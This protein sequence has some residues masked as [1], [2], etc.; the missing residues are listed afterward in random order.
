M[1][2][3]T[4]DEEL[5]SKFPNLP[6]LDTA[7]IFAKGQF[8][9]SPSA[10]F[11]LDSLK[12]HV[13][14]GVEF[15]SGSRIDGVAVFT[16]PCDKIVTRINVALRAPLP[17]M[18]AEAKLTAYCGEALGF[19]LEFTVKD[20]AVAPGVSFS[21]VNVFFSVVRSEATMGMWAINATVLAVGNGGEDDR[22]QRDLC[23]TYEHPEKFPEC[24]NGGPGQLT[25]RGRLM[26]WTGPTDVPI[27][28]VVI[29]ASPPPPPDL[30]VA[31]ASDFYPPPYTDVPPAPLAAECCNGLDPA[32]VP[33][34]QCCDP[35]TLR[36]LRPQGHVTACATSGW[37]NTPDTDCLS[38][39]TLIPAAKT[40][41]N[42]MVPPADD[43]LP[44]LDL[45]PPPLLNP[46]VAYPPPPKHACEEGHNVAGCAC[47]SAGG[48]LEQADNPAESTG[49]CCDQATKKTLRGTQVKV[50]AWCVKYSPPPGPPPPSP[51]SRLPPPSPRQ[52]RSLL[53]G[54]ADA[55]SDDFAAPSA[56][57]VAP[58][59]G[60]APVPSSESCCNANHA[61][62]LKAITSSHCC[63]Q[64][65]LTL[66]E[67]GTQC[68][69]SRWCR[70]KNCAAGPKILKSAK[71][72]AASIPAL[73]AAKPAAPPSPPLS[74]SEV[75]AVV[76]PAPVPAHQCCNANGVDWESIAAGECCDQDTLTRVAGGAQ[77]TGSGWCK[78]KDCVAALLLDRSLEAPG[79]CVA[80]PPPPRDRSSHGTH[81][82]NSTDATNVTAAAAEEEEDLMTNITLV[83]DADTGAVTKVERTYEIEAEVDVFYD[84]GN[85]ELELHGELVIG[86]QCE[87]FQVLADVEVRIAEPKMTTTGVG[88]P[89]I[90]QNILHH[91]FHPSACWVTC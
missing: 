77:C 88:P 10:G 85:V 34:G 15:G 13:Q 53:T 31:I 89:Q 29:P 7:S 82:G 70:A 84:D 22:T 50:W 23:K 79:G 67:G 16:Y 17:H 11:S 54:D 9:V 49:L 18:D 60:S 37:C 33:K 4:L 55:A 81:G 5:L 78:M 25:W 56:A 72:A 52:R 24:K 80:A 59:E 83:A 20:L 58:A 32:T 44:P 63:D 40:C 69:S 64:E 75:P 73:P 62:L 65:T 38:S 41:M 90:A 46:P 43:M 76:G 87:E 47:G 71:C 86:Q 66:V 68:M 26:F 48:G 35:A 2:S 14:V 51:P 91:M 57:P 30:P 3:I 39:A 27:A 28:A 12:V 8:T 1:G 21:L 42:H 6:G 45:M 36:L 74:P 61:D 19:D